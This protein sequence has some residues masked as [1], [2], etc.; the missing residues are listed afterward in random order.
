MKNKRELQLHRHL[1]HEYG[2][3]AANVNIFFFFFK[4]GIKK[5][6]DLHEYSTSFDDSKDQPLFHLK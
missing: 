5:Q 2:N 4:V 3:V 6:A 1:I